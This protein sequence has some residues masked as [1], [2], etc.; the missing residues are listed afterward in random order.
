VLLTP[1]QFW[2]CW[3]KELTESFRNAPV[4]ASDNMLPSD[5]GISIDRAT[6]GEVFDTND[7][8]SR[9][10]AKN[11]EFAWKPNL[12]G[13][14]TA[15][16]GDMCYSSNLID[17]SPHRLFVSLHDYLVDSTKSGYTFTEDDWRQ[18]KARHA[19]PRL[20]IIS[21]AYKIASTLPLVDSIGKPV[22]SKYKSENITDYLIFGV[23]RARALS[24]ILDTTQTPSDLSPGDAALPDFFLTTF[25]SPNFVLSTLAR[26]LRSARDAIMR[27]YK[28]RLAH[29][30]NGPH[31]Q[32]R[33]FELLDEA[34]LKASAAYAALLPSPEQRA[35]P[36]VQTWMQ[37]AVPGT[38]SLWDLLKASA[39][40]ALQP[41]FAWTVAGKAICYL[42]A[43][44]AAPGKKGPVLV[45]P[46]LFGVL[47]V[48]KVKKPGKGK[49]SRTGDNEGDREGVEGSDGKEEDEVEDTL[50]W[51]NGNG[52]A[53][54]DEHAEH[55]HGLD[56][57]EEEEEEEEEDAE[58]FDAR[59]SPLKTA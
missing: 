58:F 12:L 54:C 56:M 5:L 59:S 36:V 10:L 13:M 32:S 7:D 4:P 23:A 39:A 50:G 2:I 53:G 21:P 14:S 43:H 33:K 47:K 34:R 31:D 22:I 24:Y 6:L 18:F 8:P 11:F 25:R 29:M 38:P 55:T 9:F 19:D 17:S 44:A 48:G 16:L 40:A 42:R 57:R 20:K 1:M 28:V 15:F 30:Q 49:R 45:V 35:E 27:D 51:W 52:V 41:E 26:N 3:Q 37:Q 46:E